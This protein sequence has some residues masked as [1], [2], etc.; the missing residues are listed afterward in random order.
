MIQMLVS[1]LMSTCIAF[2]TNK[3]VREVRHIVI[4]ARSSPEEY[5]FD[6]GTFLNTVCSYLELF[7]CVFLTQSTYTFYF[8]LLITCLSLIVFI[9]N[10]KVT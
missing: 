4:I 2:L 10:I 6:V 7:L 3:S 5:D 9:H 8:F 1:V